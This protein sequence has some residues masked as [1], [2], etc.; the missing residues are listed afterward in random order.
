MW[1]REIDNKEMEDQLKEL[2]G[3]LR[4]SE[5]RRKEVERDL[6]IREQDLAIALASSA[7]VCFFYLCEDSPTFSCLSLICFHAILVHVTLKIV[8]PVMS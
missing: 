4:Q 1:E 7:S 6:K 2:V 3:L 8:L 5:T